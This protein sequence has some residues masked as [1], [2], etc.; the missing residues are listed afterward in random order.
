V[1]IAQRSQYHFC[2]AFKEVLGEPPRRYQMSHRTERAKVLLAEPSLSVPD[3]AAVG[4][5][6]AS[7]FSGLFGRM[8]GL[9]RRAYR[10]KMDLGPRTDDL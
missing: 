1:A 10:L 6:S 2:R 9:S 4:Y 8:T 7:Q 5:N 3:V